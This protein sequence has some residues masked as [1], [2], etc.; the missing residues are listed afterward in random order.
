MPLK[1]VI[2][3]GDTEVQDFQGKSQ[4]YY[5]KMHDA[6][7]AVMALV[8]SRMDI[9]DPE[10][11][12][13]MN[14]L[15]EKIGADKAQKLITSILSFNTSSQSLRM[16]PEERFNTWMGLGHNDKD[17][18]NTV[19]LFKNAM[20]GYNPR[21]SYYQQN[22]ANTSRVEGTNQMPPTEKQAQKDFEL[23]MLMRGV[24]KKNAGN[25]TRQF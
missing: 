19:Q 4:D 16:N 22:M 2:K 12:T 14:Y 23:N 21:T 6:K 18:E 13:N 25:A 9:K 3:A 24:M 20:G 17:V 5:D 11:R 8:G 1:K 10:F 7:D 15:R